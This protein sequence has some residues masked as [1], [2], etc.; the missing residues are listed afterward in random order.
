MSDHKDVEMA[1][2]STEILMEDEDGLIVMPSGNHKPRE[3]Q[4]PLLEEKNDADLEVEVEH[5]KQKHHHKKSHQS[6]M[7]KSGI[8]SSTFTLNPNYQTGELEGGT[9]DDKELP[10]EFE[11]SE[12]VRCDQYYRERIEMSLFI[13]NS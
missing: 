5:F 8:R 9:H 3:S 4:L 7:D 12:E 10:P 11:L 6:D 13:I 1:E 2:V